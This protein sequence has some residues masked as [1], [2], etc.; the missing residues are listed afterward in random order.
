MTAEQ[1]C[2]HCRFRLPLPENKIKSK[3]L[4]EDG[5]SVVIYGFCLATFEPGEELDTLCRIPESDSKC[6]VVLLFSNGDSEIGQP[7]VINNN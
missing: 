3:Q 5:R 6:P 2:N 7:H 4:D 1:H